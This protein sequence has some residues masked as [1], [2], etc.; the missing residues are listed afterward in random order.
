MEPAA[1]PPPVDHN[2]NL[3]K[4]CRTAEVIGAEWVLRKPPRSINKMSVR[5]AK[6]AELY[7]Q[8]ICQMSN[9][10]RRCDMFIGMLI[11]HQPFQAV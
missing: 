8:E 3:R 7:F 1:G 2:P 6:R 9:D 4:D 11:R 10:K 5:P